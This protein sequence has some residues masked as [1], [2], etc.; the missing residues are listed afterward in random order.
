LLNKKKPKNQ[1]KMEGKPMYFSIQ[2]ITSLKQS[3]SLEKLIAQYIELKQHADQFVGL[4]PFHDDHHPS[5][6][7]FVQTQSFYCFG[8]HAGSK[9]VTASSDHIAFLMHYH[10][11]PFPKAVELLAEITQ[12]PLPNH[13]PSSTKPQEQSQTTTPPQTQPDEQFESSLPK[14]NQDPICQQIFNLAAQFYHQ[15]LFQPDAQFAL[16]YLIQQ[17]GRTLD[18]IKQ[19][20]IGFAKGG[21]ALYQFLKSKGFADDQ[22]LKSQLIAQRGKRLLDYFFGNILIFPHCHNNKIISFTIKDLGQYKSPLKL[23]LFSRNNFYNQDSLDDQ[24]QQIILVEGESDLHSIVQFTDHN[25]VLALCGNQLTH[26]Q[27]K[28][29]SNANFS[30][31]YLALDRDAAGKKASQAISNKLI[32]AGITVC[33]LTWNCHKDIDLYLRFTPPDQRQSSFQQL[34]AQANQNSS[35]KATAQQAHH[36]QQQQSQN[37]K[38]PSNLQLIKELL[39]A[40]SILLTTIL[41]LLKNTKHYLQHRK[42]PSTSKIN[43][44]HRRPVFSIDQLPIYR[45]KENVPHYTV[46]LQQ[47]QQ[48]HGKPLK[49]VQR[50]PDKRKPAAQAHCQF[51]EAPATYLSLNDGNKQVYCKICHHLSNYEKQIKDVTIKCP[52]CNKTLEKMIKQTEKNGYLY[53]KCRNKKCSYFISNKNRLN[54]LSK[55]QQRKFKKLHY[56]Y[57]KPVMDITTLHPNS[58]DKPKV[59]LAQVRSSA[60]VIGLVLTYRAIGQSTRTIA[61][62][63]QEVHEVAISHQTVKNYLDAAAYRLAPMV[64]NYPYLLSGT[65]T[66][67]ETYLRVIGKWNYLTWCFDPKEQIITAL[68]VSEKRNLIELA[69]AINHAVSKFSLDELTEQATYHPLLVTDGNP[70]YQLIVQFLRQA[71]IFINHKVVIGLE[72][73]DD[74]SADFRNLKQIIERMNKNFKKYI[75]NSEYFGSTSGALSAAVIFTA[76]FNFIRKNSV[77]D[78]KIPVSIPTINPPAGGHNQPCRWIRLL[79]YAQIFCQQQQ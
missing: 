61:T 21:R 54:K 72:N 63:M 76:H 66:A 43:S 41:M 38:Q 15:Q 79:E 57:R 35:K 59:D 36:D 78:G 24:D 19:F 46:L 23:R 69:K 2:F 5:F 65:L 64:V 53:Y 70:V 6:T 9:S 18:I 49:P 26:V 13:Q 27:L 16:D 14:L 42:N 37:L 39:K 28:K 62:L 74:Q 75:N 60:Y 10:K 34:L 1:S 67:D 71:N 45:Q 55:K 11:L 17:R 44:Y 30:K 51:C 77:L 3:I 73:N 8:C 33:P 7:V 40:I 31:V 56:L 20:Q 29:I 22:L 68:N 58:P 32:N 48:S 4:C 12:T 52:H 50:K 47:Y 25:N